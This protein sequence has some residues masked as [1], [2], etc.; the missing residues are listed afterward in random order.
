M[1]GIAFQISPILKDI[2]I[3]FENINVLHTK[4]FFYPQL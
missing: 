3:S 4:H 2:N 1:I